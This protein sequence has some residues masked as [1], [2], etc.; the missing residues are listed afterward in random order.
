MNQMYN[1]R[2]FREIK[3]EPRFDY[4]GELVGH[5]ELK[6][7]SS[8]VV[9]KETTINKN[10]IKACVWHEGVKSFCVRYKKEG[11]GIVKAQEMAVRYCMEKSIG[12]IYE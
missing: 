3:K 9:T 1:P 6:D 4:V 12:V 10:M 7:R 11:F 2:L 8:L 5:F